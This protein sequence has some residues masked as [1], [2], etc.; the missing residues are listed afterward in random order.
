[1]VDPWHPSSD[2]WLSRDFRQA[3]SDADRGTVIR[4]TRQARGLGQRETAGLAGISQ[5]RLSRIER[6]YEGT[7][8]IPVMTRLA[9]VL[10]IPAHFLGLAE[11]PES[12]VNRRQF[13]V[14]S[15]AVAATPLLPIGHQHDPTDQVSGLRQIT[16]TYRRLDGYTPGRDLA[17][18]VEA[19]LAL[20]RRLLERTKKSDASYGP[21][22]EALSETAGLAAWLAYDGANLGN[23]HGHYATAIAA[24]RQADNRLLAAYMAGSRAALCADQGDPAEALSLLRSARAYL[25][26][27]YPALAEAWLAC[28]QALAHAA[29]KE[30]ILTWTALDRAEAA[31]ARV[32]REAQP[33]WPWV[34]P[35]GHS[36]IASYRLTCAARLREPRA[37]LRAATDAAPHLQTGHVRQRALLILDLAEAH[38]HQ[39]GIEQAVALACDALDLAASTGSGRVAQ[40]ARRL[41]RTVDGKVP[42]IMLRGFNDRLRAF[43]A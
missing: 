26:S 17:A 7:D 36:K 25:G 33:P 5:S 40:H 38:A 19:H 28:Q 20:G 42:A 32:D 35:F 18:P 9:E 39:G 4:L 30:N 43:A 24:A 11:S 14:N 23:A 37:A 31:A 10:N 12:P 3:V 22:A 29:A 8:G 2:L 41:R 15:A 34:F 27:G 16:G 1:M 6:G 21:L 13:L